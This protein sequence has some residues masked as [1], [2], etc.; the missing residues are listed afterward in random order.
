LKA[1]FPKGISQIKPSPSLPYKLSS[2]LHIMLRREGYSL[3][4]NAQE[5]MGEFS[6]KANFFPEE[7]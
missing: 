4:D 5:Q 6:M 1:I 7:N 3:A 2:K